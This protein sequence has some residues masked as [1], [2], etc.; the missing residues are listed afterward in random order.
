MEKDCE[1]FR[2]F[3]PGAYHPTT[4]ETNLITAG[5]RSSTWLSMPQTAGPRKSTSSCMPQQPARGRCLLPPREPRTAD[6]RI[7]KDSRARKDSRS[8]KDSR[9]TPST[10]STPSSLTYSPHMPLTRSDIGA[11][12]TRSVL[13]GGCSMCSMRIM[14]ARLPRCLFGETPGSGRTT[15]SGKTD[16]SDGPGG[17]SSTG[18]TPSPSHENDERSKRGPS[19]RDS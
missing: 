9:P 7:R 8:R 12:C 11:R 15:S 4:Y 17:K 1:L 6:V 19:Q 3:L 10:M 5:I 2:R 13:V 14:C 16:S 18:T